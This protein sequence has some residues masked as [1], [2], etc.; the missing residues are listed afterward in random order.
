LQGGELLVG[1]GLGVL[2]TGDVDVYDAP[3]VDVGREEDGREFDLE[4]DHGQ[5]AR[6]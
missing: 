1:D 4:V 2:V 3:R 5:H 6:L